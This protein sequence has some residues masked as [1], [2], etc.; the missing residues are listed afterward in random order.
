LGRTDIEDA[1]ERLD[2]LIHEEVRMVI[3]QTWKA[4]VGHNEGTQ[5]AHPVT[6]LS[7]N[8]VY[9]VNVAMAG[10]MGEVA[11]NTD[12]IE[13]NTDVIANNTDEIKCQWSD[14]FII[15]FVNTKT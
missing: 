4:T 12:I 6:H 3:A 11:K 2:N 1:F 10:D 7:L 8:R 5:T 15:C 14:P 13:K 9:P